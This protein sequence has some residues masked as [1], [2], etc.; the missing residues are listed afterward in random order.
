MSD[1]HELV[2]GFAEGAAAYERGRPGY[3][4]AV[5]ERVVAELGVVAGGRVLDLGAGTGKLARP[6]LAAGLDVVA[7][8]PLASMRAVL[9]DVVGASRALDGRAE[10]LPLADASLDGAVCA[11]A[12][13]WF[14]GARAAAELHRVLRPDGALVVM[15]LLAADGESPWGAEVR[16]LLEPLWQAARHPGLVGGHDVDAVEHNGGFAPLRRVEMRFEDAVDRT[17]ALAWFA[18]FSYVGALGERERVA[19]LERLAAVLDRHGV[20]MV[21]RPWRV[22]MWVTRRRSS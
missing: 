21:R 10:A 14:D 22:E 7:I 8:E 16:A 13:H 12:F 18:S 6:L 3:P 15:W 5:V 4:P 1:L 20:T 2:A 9:A 19:L 11:E 17:G